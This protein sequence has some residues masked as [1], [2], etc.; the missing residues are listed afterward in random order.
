[1]NCVAWHVAFA[2]CAWDGG[3]L[4]TEAEWAYAAAGGSEQRVYPWSSPPNSTLVDESDASYFVDATRECAGDGVSGCSLDD[5]LYV[6]TK[7]SGRA[8]WGQLDLGGNVWEWTL[9]AYVAPYAATSCVDCA[10]LAGGTT[11]VVRGGSF[12]YPATSM[13]SSFRGQDEPVYWS[14]DIGVRCARDL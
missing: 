13:A 12:D 6:G 11:R 14:H 7:P 9:D 10:T 2:F 1:M 3:R 4:P 5:L 8:R